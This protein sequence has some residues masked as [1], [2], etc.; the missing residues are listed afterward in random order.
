MINK[1]FRYANRNWLARMRLIGE[2]EFWLDDIRKECLDIYT[3]MHSSYGDSDAFWKASK[4]A[5]IIID[6]H[7]RIYNVAKKKADELG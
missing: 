6:K 2:L 4:K 5:D 1:M 3:F 7:A